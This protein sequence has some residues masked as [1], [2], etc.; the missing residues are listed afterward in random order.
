MKWGSIQS[1]ELPL[2]L[3]DG[4]CGIPVDKVIYKS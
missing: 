1:N 3:D 4:L 2:S